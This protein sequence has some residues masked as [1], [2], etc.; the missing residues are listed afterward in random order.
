MI[1][2]GLVLCCILLGSAQ[3]AIAQ[4]NLTVA[5]SESSG[6]EKRVALV[7]G[8]SAYETSPLKNPVNDA[9]VMASKLRAVGFDVLYKEN[10]K[11]KQIGKTMMEF[12]SML[13]PG[14]VALIFYAG[15]GLQ[16]KGINYL[17]AVDAE[18]SSE[19]DVPLQS[20]ELSRLLLL[21]EESKTSMNLVFL[22]ACRNNPFA[23]SFRS[24]SS[25]LARVEAPS[26]T[27]I[28]YATRPGSVAA[29]GDGENG[30]YTAQLIQQIE[31]QDVPIETVLKRV[32]AGVKRTSKGAQEPWM[33]GSIEGEFFF[34]T[35][36]PEQKAA[37]QRAAEK[38]AADKRVAEQRVAEQRAA[39]QRAVEQL[40][41]E[42]RATEQRAAERRAAEQRAA[43]QR[44]GEQLAA[45]KHAAEQ[46]AAAQRE[47]EQRES[48]KQAAARLAAEQKAAEQKRINT[49]LA[50]LSVPGKPSVPSS[51][52]PPNGT[53][54]SYR[55]KRLNESRIES[56]VV[57]GEGVYDG[58][59]VFRV[60]IDGK[61][62]LMLYDL[63]T[64]NWMKTIRNGRTI[65]TATP[66]E[67]IFRFPLVEGGN[68]SSQYYGSDETACGNILALVE[69]KAREKIEVPAGIFDVNLVKVQ[70]RYFHSG[71]NSMNTASKIRNK[72]LWFSPD[73]R[74]A[75]KIEDVDT[76]TSVTT[77]YELLEYSVQ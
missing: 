18:I 72:S 10:I 55:V 13:S 60:S 41:A 34:K 25:G 9:R 52:F 66:Y 62:G 28:S 67:D 27:L 37:E 22:D 38:L 51:L 14:A 6:L 2:L 44:A 75:V 31:L 58:E 59:K 68:H 53:R 16:I 61:N 11:V 48:Q 45:E 56:L 77:R 54:Y 71:T 35:T 40:A 4:R 30:L 23:R 63:K 24:A 76:T 47:A 26:G 74:V 21:L 17:P 15:H 42:K 29:D 64:G 19:L 69:V 73:L 3:D 5:R 57:L 1:R 20:F 36:S 32:T 33:E 7:I 50:L 43:E 70:L 46:R 8:N 49:N 65:E 39:E 12:R